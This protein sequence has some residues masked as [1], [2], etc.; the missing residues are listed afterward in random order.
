MKNKK[1]LKTGEVLRRLLAETKTSLK[2]VGI[3]TGIPI[4]SLSQI[5]QGRPIRDMG[6]ARAIASYF[7]ISLFFLLWGEDDP[8]TPNIIHKLETDEIFKGTYEI[9]LKK[10]SLKN[11]ESGGKNEKN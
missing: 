8:A 1:Q 11:R 4:S 6:N 2:E 10:V 7:G 9:T 3:A 5:K